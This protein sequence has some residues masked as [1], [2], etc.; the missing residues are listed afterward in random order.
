MTQL[1]GLGDAAV[2]AAAGNFMILRWR[3]FMRIILTKDDILRCRIFSDACARTQQRIE[4]GEASSQERGDSEIARDNMIGKLGEVAVQKAFALYG[5]RIEL[6][7]E[8]YDRGQWD[9]CD[10]FHNGW[11]LD[12]KCT[13]SRSRYF[14]IE[15]NK[16]QFR[17]DAG[18]LPHFFVMARLLDDGV[19]RPERRLPAKTDVEIEGFVDVRQLFK[20]ASEIAKVLERGERIP[21]TKTPITAKS[22]CVQ[23]AKL[24]KKIKRLAEKLQNE[25]PFAIGPLHLANTVRK[26][27][28]SRSG[29]AADRPDVVKYSL[30]L[31]GRHA[32]HLTEAEVEDFRTRGLKLFVF[33]S[34][35]K[36]K[37]L[38]G[39]FSA[40]LEDRGF[41]NI[42]AVDEGAPD[43][44]IKDGRRSAPE[45]KALEQ[46]ASMSGGFNF[47]QYEIEHAAS[48]VPIIVKAS[49]GTGK[50]TVMV[51]RIAY[52]LA[53]NDTLD[54]HEIAM[55]T[56]TNKAASSMLEKIH[57]RLLKLHERTKSGKWLARLEGV[58]G[59]LLCTIDS[60]FHKILETEGGALGYGAQARLTSF[61]YEK[62]K[63]ID[64]IVDSLLQKSL[65]QTPAERQLDFCGLNLHQLQELTLDIWDKLHARGLFLQS[66]WD[67]DFGGEQDNV[68]ADRANKLAEAAVKS[69]E[70]R[71]QLL[72]QEQNAYAVDDLKSEVD[73]LRHAVNGGLRFPR[74][75]FIFVDEFQ[76]TDHSQIRCLVWL[77]KIMNCQL[78]VVGDVKQSIYRFRGAEESAFDE[79][80]GI[81]ARPESN[82]G[83]PKTFVLIKNYRT[84]K[85]L[86]DKLNAFF[87]MKAGDGL[88]PPWEGDAQA[89]QSN[90]HARLLLHQSRMSSL[91]KKRFF[92]H[93]VLPELNFLRKRSNHICFL[94]RQNDQA[95]DI[96]M[97][98]RKSGIFCSVK[99]N[100]DFFD[101][102]SV[103]DL[104]ALLGALVYP[105]DAK[106]L[107]N[108]LA[109]PYFSVKPDPKQILS[110]EG[111]ENKITACLQ[112]LLESQEWG[113]FVEALRH[114][115]FFRLLERLMTKL[116]PA[117]HYEEELRNSGKTENEV[118][119]LAQCYRLNLNKLLNM[120]YEQ[121]AGDYASLL[122]AYS[123]LDLKIQTGFKEDSLYPEVSLEQ[124]ECIEVMTVHKAKGL[125]FDAVVM[126]YLDVPFFSKEGLRSKVLI[127]DRSP[128]V[129]VGWKLDKAMKSRNYDELALNEIEATRRDEARLLYVALT[130]AKNHLLLF[131]PSYV[132]EDTWA[133]MLEPLRHK[134]EREQ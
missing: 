93:E 98:C 54:P 123:W 22:F 113:E 121:F 1:L 107:W 116:Q 92:E 70:M 36:D 44:C 122:D 19:L 40:H 59:M 75:K 106:R 16:L 31:S 27:A 18:Q 132:L 32:E 24:N 57:A 69:A 26:A 41:L 46:L 25:R 124:G 35:K 87:R 128:A 81:L 80:Q 110:Y 56:F 99:V 53:I 125:E 12:V 10:I 114:E 101:Q 39:W 21:G 14:L 91:D 2:G 97:F 68:K 118:S 63:I 62:K 105:H 23:F 20:T 50:T 79:L 94:V 76:D 34:E 5:L 30:L 84:A 13:K 109:T 86:V 3:T 58:S 103:R 51:D 117:L 73:A 126:P 88:L 134:G 129:K 55:V 8:I 42:F 119:H 7:F 85:T 133:S 15:W 102:P 90:P 127:D 29:P 71:Y 130:R 11:M 104:H 72:K 45:Q 74:L 83:A 52:L 100:D 78:F 9:E 61:V 37:Q 115:Q 82:A 112:T 111:E 96:A 67:A 77:Q 64:E 60:F 65:R 17:S 120:L 43:L 33:A 95:R 6:D 49:A 47:Q 89:V 48:H 66:V 4:F 108:V 131:M 38:R 28:A